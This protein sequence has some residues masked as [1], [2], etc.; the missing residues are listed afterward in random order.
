M[1]V[2]NASGAF[3]FVGLILVIVFVSFLAIVREYRPAQPEQQMREIEQRT[4]V[5][6]VNDDG[7]RLAEEALERLLDQ[8]WRVVQIENMSGLNPMALLLLE[9]PRRRK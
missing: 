5:F 7:S 6:T 8:D 3:S 2:S 9:R 1:T 4:F